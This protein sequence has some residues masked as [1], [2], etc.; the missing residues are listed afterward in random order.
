MSA[1][2]S[3]LQI[4]RADGTV[5]EA[6]VPCR[7]WVD[8][9]K[10]AT[11]PSCGGP[12]Q[13]Q[14]GISR[15]ELFR[16]VNVMVRER[17]QATEML[18]AAQEKLAAYIEVARC[19]KA[20][21]EAEQARNDALAETYMES[22]QGLVVAENRAYASLAVAVQALE[23]GA[24]SAALQTPP[25]GPASLASPALVRGACQAHGCN[26]PRKENG[27]S[28]FCAEHEA[29]RRTEDTL[30]RQRNAVAFSDAD[31]EGFIGS[32]QWRCTVEEVQATAARLLDEKKART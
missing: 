29:A 13:Q 1:V 23:L 9:D 17:N 21:L 27:L 3:G 16:I 31:L 22:R 30:I 6:R 12:R 19:A 24:G 18:T 2:P 28:M 8:G 25:T 26:Q 15:D 7:T 14:E 11:C 32:G 10:T 5:A 4:S 20:L